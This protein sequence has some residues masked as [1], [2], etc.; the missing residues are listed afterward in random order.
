MTD[1]HLNDVISDYKN[2]LSIPRMNCDVPL[3]IDE[4]EKLRAENELWESR[5]NSA[6]KEFDA[7]LEEIKKL[8]EA[9]ELCNQFVLEVSHAMQSGPS[10]YTKG[11][12]GLRNQVHMWI[13][14]AAKAIKA[15]L[16][17][18]DD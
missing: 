10:W 14:R 2:G 11:E 4:V 12:S 1:R 3:L 13:D 7:A 9:L 17:V 6:I 8:R 16:E 15:A 18:N 5:A